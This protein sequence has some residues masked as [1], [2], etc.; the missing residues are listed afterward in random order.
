LPCKFRGNNY[1][2]Q[3]L[4]SAAISNLIWGQV[5]KTRTTAQIQNIELTCTRHA[6]AAAAVHAAAIAGLIYAPLIEARVT[7]FAAAVVMRL[8]VCTIHEALPW[9]IHEDA[10]ALPPAPVAAPALAPTSTAAVPLHLLGHRMARD[11]RACNGNDCECLHELSP[12][13]I[14]Y[15]DGF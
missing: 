4:L 6:S 1:S 15:F 3:T 8:L 14:I 2:A 5:V 11:H 10:S 12:V 9:N 7:D 13:E